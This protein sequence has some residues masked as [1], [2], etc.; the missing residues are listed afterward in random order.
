MLTN[1]WSKI[2]KSLHIKKQRREQGLFVI[3]GEKGLIELLNSKFEIEAFFVTEK[4]SNHYPDLIENTPFSIN[5]EA[6]IKKNSSL[7]TND[8]GIAIVKIP[9]QDI[10]LGHSLLVLDNIQDPGN[11]GT[12]IRTA[13]WY[14]IDTVV[15]SENT[16][17]K[18]NHKVVQSAMGS[19][20]RVP[21]IYTD[22]QSFI[23]ENKGQFTFHTATLQGENLHQTEFDNNPIAIVMGNES[24]GVSKDI[25]DLCDKELMIPRF[26]GAESLNVAM[27]SAIFCDNYRRLFPI[28]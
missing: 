19:L 10:N 8:S 16:V 17:D 21:V 14:G 2:I 23:K 22:L 28:K 6:L 4:F 20:F 25:I 1:R 24:K 15:C 9:N 13:D 27:A 3:E 5:E 11:L 7:I 18:Y 26:G 12:I